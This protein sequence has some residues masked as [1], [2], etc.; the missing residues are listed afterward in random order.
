MDT[1]PD[2]AP[3]QGKGKGKADDDMNITPKE[4]P[5]KVA[6]N[7][8]TAPDGVPEAAT[9]DD[10]MAGNASD[11]TARPNARDTSPLT[12][13]EEEDVPM[14]SPPRPTKPSSKV[15]TAKPAS[16]RVKRSRV[17]SQ[18]V[19]GPSTSKRRAVDTNNDDDE[20]EPLPADA[21]AA[22]RVTRAGTKVAAMKKRGTGKGLPP[23]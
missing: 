16:E 1:R 15:Q 3:T 13:Q 12:A 9:D 6:D 20:L 2:G 11:D 23:Q 5:A 22:Q 21:A 18:P 17:C 7:M 14:K 10:A 4:V 8:N 19:A